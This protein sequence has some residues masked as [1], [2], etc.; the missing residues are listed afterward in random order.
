MPSTP[1]DPSKPP[2]RKRLRRR[3]TGHNPRFLTFSCY[4]RLQ[5]FGTPRLR[6]FF[7]ESLREA[8]CERTF[9]L[10]AWVIMPEHV[11]MMV[12][13]AEGVVWAPIAAG[14]KTSVGKT[15]IN[16]WRRKRAAILPRLRDANGAHHFWQPGG[17][18]DRNVRHHAEL[19]KEIRYIHRNPVERGLVAAPTDW[20]WSSARW[21][22]NRHTDQPQDAADLPCMWPPGDPKSWKHWSG[23]M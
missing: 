19:E 20:P 10:I 21:W 1:P 18:F 16:Q 14:F 8:M 7:V 11:H 6:N 2:H 17:G 5:L 13:P 12:C 15:I 9:E 4:H 23:F 3:E 22:A